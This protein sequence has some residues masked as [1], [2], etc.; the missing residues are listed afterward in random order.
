MIN[1]II[2]AILSIF[3]FSGFYY[4]DFD[5]IVCGDMRTCIHEQGH[6]MDY[7][8]GRPSQ[9]KEFKDTVD[10]VL[11]LLIK[12]TSCIVETENCLYSEAYALLWEMTE[13]NNYKMLDEFKE[14]YKE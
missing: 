4:A 7:Q 11:P 12:G 13:F 6:R 3:G 10:E 14:F 2:L 5:Y 8:L 9:T 1:N